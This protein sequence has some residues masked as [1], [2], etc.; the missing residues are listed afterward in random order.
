MPLYHRNRNHPEIWEECA[1]DPCSLHSDDVR[2]DSFEDLYDKIARGDSGV[3]YKLGF[4]V[5][6]RDIVTIIQPRVSESVYARG[7]K[8]MN[9]YKSYK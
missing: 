4:S 5:G 6:S 8:L 3:Q 7:E 1:H 9:L 2:A